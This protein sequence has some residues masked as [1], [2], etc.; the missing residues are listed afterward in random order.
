MIK[1]IGCE[2]VILGHSERRHIFME[3]DKV[4]GEKVNHA[5]SECLK[6]IACIG[7]K[8]S[9]REA[10]KTEE[11]CFRQMEAIRRK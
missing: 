1:N 2:W 8:L 6:V 10:G 9:E 4:I 11:V 3:N 5:L 7:E